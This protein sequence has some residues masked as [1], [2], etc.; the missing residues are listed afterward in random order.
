MKAMGP[1][2]DAGASKPPTR[3]RT[4]FLKL[5]AEA[6]KAHRE[7]GDRLDQMEALVTSGQTHPAALEADF[8]R[9]WE[10]HTG[11]RYVTAHARDRGVLKRLLR[12]VEADEIRVRMGRYFLLTDNLV[13]RER[14]S[15]TL[16]GQMINSLG[17]ASGSHAVGDTT[18]QAVDAR[19]ELDGWI[20]GK[21]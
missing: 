5:L 10:L 4:E 19:L 3:A 11:D 2:R 18:R 12:S 16:F 1:G 6:R 13:Q 15:L 8:I 20:R 9:A 14:W 17:R 21:D 7:Q